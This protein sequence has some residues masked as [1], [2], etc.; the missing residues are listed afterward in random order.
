MCIGS[1][2]PTLVLA[3]L[4]GLAAGCERPAQPAQQ[5]AELKRINNAGSRPMPNVVDGAP[6]RFGE[7][8]I[9][10]VGPNNS[11]LGARADWQVTDTPEKMQEFLRAK[12]TKARPELVEGRAVD[13]TLRC[14]YF[15]EDGG[16]T[17]TDSLDLNIAEASKGRVR[18]K[19]LGVGGRVSRIDIELEAI[20][21]QSQ[22]HKVNVPVKRD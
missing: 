12:V 7:I 20:V 4:L 16:A 9:S 18:F 11:T 22:G 1:T 21:W 8:G 15:D 14:S 3:G 19:N 10:V 6:L 17:G 5:H 2:T 13:L